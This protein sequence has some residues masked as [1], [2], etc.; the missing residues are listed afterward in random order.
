M[1][2][3][4]IIYIY[5]QII[6]DFIIFVNQTNKQFI[7][8][9]EQTNPSSQNTEPHNGDYVPFNFT[10]QT[11]VRGPSCKATI[12]CITLVNSA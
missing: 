5:Y 9:V 4:L 12:F 1:L 6:L 11:K 10:Q 7:P 3:T 8:F 2:T